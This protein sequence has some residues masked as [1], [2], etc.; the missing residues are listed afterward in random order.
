MSTHEIYQY[1]SLKNF[2]LT[3]DKVLK[4]PQSSP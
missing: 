1:L 4:E 2:N 3:N